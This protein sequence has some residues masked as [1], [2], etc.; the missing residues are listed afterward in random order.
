MA[1]WDLLLRV[2]LLL[3]AAAAIGLLLQRLRQSVI[4]GYLIAGLL[5]GPTG[6]G[7]VRTGTDIQVL[8]ELGVALLLFSIGL[9]FSFARLRQFGAVAVGAGVLQMGVTALVFTL[10]AGLGFGLAWNTAIVLGMA[11]GMS[12]T[13][14]VLRGLT[15]RAELDST[16][17]RNAI[18]ILLFQDVAV[19]PVLIAADALGRAS[20]TDGWM[21]QLG[22]R[23]GLIVLFVAGAGLV[24]RYVLPQLLSAAAVSGSR[25]LPVVIAVV[26]S[27]GAA[28]GAHAL[29]FSPSLGAFIAGL[30][31]AESPFATQ[32][33]ADLTPLSAVFVTLFFA[34]VGT[35]VQLPPQ[36]VYVAGLVAAAVL[37]MGLKLMIT[38]GALRMMGQPLRVALVTGA[39]ISQVGEF[40]FVV[41]ENG[42]RSGLI[43]EAVFQWT[44]G[45]S[46]VTLLMTPYV[47][48]M[49]PLMAARAA[50]RVPALARSGRTE[51][52]AGSRWERVIVIG[53]GP[54]GQEV[55][56]RLQSAGVPFLVLETNPHTVTQYR[57]RLSIEMG[58]ASQPEVLLHAGVGQSHSVVVTVPDPT[59]ARLICAAVQRL[60]PGT[61]IIVRCR[62]HLHREALRAAGADHIVDEEEFVGVKLADEAMATVISARPA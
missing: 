3:G 35:A 36:P 32:V 55:A 20:G 28:W 43:P 27:I 26:A 11:F 48:R 54:A 24:S 2:V 38:S 9:E 50:R 37:A 51:M 41:V 39:V 4:V 49:A 23:I 6:F 16:H 34:S 7:L 17:G 44:L 18:G 47:L 40:T 12:S 29:G 31:I 33:R 45:I 52:P 13:A 53:F 5:L 58:D 42:H 8:S 56:A 22:F 10:I 1:G 57:S 30:M 14:V 46:I 25:D 60:A 61:P 59:A 62:Y 15:E 21:G 19:I